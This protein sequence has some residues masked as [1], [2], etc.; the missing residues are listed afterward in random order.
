MNKE[1]A[2]AFALKASI[3]KNIMSESMYGNKAR[4]Q[5]YHTKLYAAEQAVQNPGPFD[6][7]VSHN[8]SPLFSL[9]RPRYRGKTSQVE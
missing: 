9:T 1:L 8:S 2:G 7:L 3:L 5:F 4:I 6:T